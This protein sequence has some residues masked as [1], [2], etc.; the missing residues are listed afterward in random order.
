MG[1]PFYFLAL[2]HRP[3]QRFHSGMEDIEEQ[4]VARYGEKAV[5]AWMADGQ[6]GVRRYIDMVRARSGIELYLFAGQEELLQGDQAPAEARRMATGVFI[7]DPGAPDFPRDEK[8]IGK[9]LDV[10]EELPGAPDMVVAKLPKPPEP[11][12]HQ[13]WN[14]HGPLDHILLYSL[15]GGLVCYFLARSLTAPIR[16]LREATNSLAGGDFSVRVGKNLG[17]QGSEVADLGRDF[18]VMAE[19]IEALLVSQK[20]LLRDISHELRSPL[21]RLNVALELARQRAG[22]EAEQPLARIE[23]ESRRLN[24]LIGELLI[25]TRVESGAQP[26]EQEDFIL[27][28]LLEMVVADASFEAIN[29][30]KAVRLVALDT[31]ALHGSREL[32]RRAFENVVRNAVHYTAARTTVELNLVREVGGQLVFITVA[33]HGP[34]VPEESLIH[35]FEPFYRVAEARDRQTGGSGIGLTIAERAVRL[36]GG[37]MKA[38]NG[39]HGGL[40]VTVILPVA[41]VA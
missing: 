18:D 11:P 20:L 19:K 21:A 33:D 2:Q 9:Q 10:E 15:A 40:V 34:G 8:W 39:V 36:H 4:A 38:A 25:L 24:E 3:P 32:M 6:E 29:H 28:D 12:P 30:D 35:L 27:N 7:G 41:N 14:H 37:M 23:L 5:A 31:V 26:L 13:S 16:K 1:V 17:R 22:E